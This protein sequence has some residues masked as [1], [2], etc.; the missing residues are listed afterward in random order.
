MNTRPISRILSVLLL[1]CLL[2]G[3]QL[4]ALADELYI[5]TELSF[6]M[7]EGIGSRN[8]SLNGVKKTSA[9]TKLKSSN[10]KVATVSKFEYEGTAY[11][12]VEPKSPGNTTVTFRVKYNG[13]TVKGKVAVTV[14]KYVNPF[15]ALKIGTRSCASL[16]NKTDR[17]Y[18]AKTLKGKITYKLKKGWELHSIHRYNAT[19]GSNFKSLNPK[20]S[21]TVKKGYRLSFELSYKGGAWREYWIEVR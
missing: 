15:K 16:F 13:K 9:I 19:N 17:V 14:L 5:P 20:K 21:N 10:P 8:I 3:M 12:A 6:Q 7:S 18:T 11:V 4:P 2:V 1:M